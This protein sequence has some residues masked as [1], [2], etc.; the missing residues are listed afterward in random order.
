M[1]QCQPYQGA[2]RSSPSEY[3]LQQKSNQAL[4]FQNIYPL[5]GHSDMWTFNFLFFGNLEERKTK[6]DTTIVFHIFYSYDY[7]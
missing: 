7:A 5:L 1:I 6:Q 4:T 3:C 2:F